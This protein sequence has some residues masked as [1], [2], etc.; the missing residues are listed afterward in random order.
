MFTL[1]NYNFFKFQHFKQN[2]ITKI[3]RKF[4]TKRILIRFTILEINRFNMYLLIQ[5]EW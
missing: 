3:K 4:K 2:N 5:Y 1:S